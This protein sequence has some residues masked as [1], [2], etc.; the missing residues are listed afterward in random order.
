MFSRKNLEKDVLATKNTRDGVDTSRESLSE[1]NH[2]GLDGGIVLEAKE[3]TGTS[4]TL[5]S[6]HVVRSSRVRSGERR[7]A[8]G[9]NFNADEENVV[10]LAKGLNSLKVI[11][12]RNDDTV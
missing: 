8:Y 1:E 2:V 10:L 7:K 5:Y 6:F 12:I 4:E 3:F 11:F 9:L